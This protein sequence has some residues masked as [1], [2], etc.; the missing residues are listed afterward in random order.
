[1]SATISLSQGWGILFRAMTRQKF[2]DLGVCAEWMY[3][4]NVFARHAGWHPIADEIYEIKNHLIKYLYQHGYAYEVK[5]HS[6]KRLCHSCGGDGIYW[7]GG[8]CYKCDGT[9]IYAITRLYAF[10]FD[11]GGRKYAWHQLAKFID[12]DVV[13][14]L[15]EV[16]SYAGAKGD[17]EG[18]IMSYTDAWLGCC[19]LWLGLRVHGAKPHSRLFDASHNWGVVRLRKVV[20][21]MKKRFLSSAREDDVPF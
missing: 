14:T 13:C 5:L 1:M 10:R 21:G 19:V 20:D 4:L 12:Y 15:S 16:E 18:A 9:G 2:W 17:E 11:V 3:R 6:Q 7:T 8:E